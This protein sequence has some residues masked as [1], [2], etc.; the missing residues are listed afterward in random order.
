MP[1]DVLNSLKTV[2]LSSHQF[3]MPGFVDCHIHAPQV[4]QIGLGLDLPLLQWLDT[5]TFPLE[6]YYSDS[7]FAL[8]VYREVIVSFF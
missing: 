8:K 7:E 2:T 6:A 1:A 3:L 4:A 5:Y